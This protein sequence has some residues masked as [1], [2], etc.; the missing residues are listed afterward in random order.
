MRLKEKKGGQEVKDLS[1]EELAFREKQSKDRNVFATRGL[2]RVRGR[3][4]RKIAM[5]KNTKNT[6]K[7]EHSSGEQ[8]HHTT[9]TGSS[10]LFFVGTSFVSSFSSAFT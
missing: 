9:R 1:E 8:H 3:S 2:V 4:V 6:N 10:V 5:L 7:D